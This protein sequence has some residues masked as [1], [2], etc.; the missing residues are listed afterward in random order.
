MNVASARTARINQTRMK[1]ALKKKGDIKD[2]LGEIAA[3]QKAH[4]NKQF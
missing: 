3:V 2:L 1:V 4:K